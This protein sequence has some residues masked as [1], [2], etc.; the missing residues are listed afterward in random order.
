MALVYNL[1]TMSRK[2]YRR[3]TSSRRMTTNYDKYGYEIA[4]L[5]SSSV[6]N[7]K[8]P[9]M[10]VLRVQPGVMVNFI[11]PPSSSSRN[12]NRSWIPRVVEYKSRRKDS[13][14]HFGED[15]RDPSRPHSPYPRSPDFDDRN[16][17]GSGVGYERPPSPR[18]PHR[19]P[20]THHFI[21]G[22]PFPEPPFHEP[23]FHEP[24][25]HEPPFHEPPYHEP[26]H[27]EPLYSEPHHMET[28]YPEPHHM[29]PHYPMDSHESP[30]HVPSPIDI[31]AHPRTFD[32]SDYSLQSPSIADSDL[33]R[34]NQGQSDE[35]CY[36]DPH[37]SPVSIE[38]PL[39]NSPSPRSR[40][41]SFDFGKPPSPLN[42]NGR[43]VRFRDD[44]V[45]PSPPARRKGWWNRKG[46]QL[47]DND[48]A[49][50]AAPEHDQYPSDLRNYPEAGTGWMN[51]EGVQ[52][53]MKRRLVRKKPLRSALKKSS[54]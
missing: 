25:F 51:E 43:T 52:I 27:M 21:P 7:G 28:C 41:R 2:S 6:A 19:S 54:L 48:G 11:E 31:P 45:S 33:T 35:P 30:R 3:G 53:D 26:H 39:R 50:A 9:V 15:P 16:P 23:P 18:D 13:H 29:E 44:P 46:E 20:T 42:S 38:M 34:F 8:E 4:T 22:E 24:L 40:R 10:H 17:F 32:H 14:S 5:G 37:Q 47:W 49:Y 12:R 1:D 36:F